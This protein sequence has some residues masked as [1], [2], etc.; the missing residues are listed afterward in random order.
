MNVS[1]MTNEEIFEEMTS[2]SKRMK[3]LE[4][5]RNY[6]ERN[7]L[8]PRWK[9]LHAAYDFGFSVGEKIETKAWGHLQEAKIIQVE[10]TQFHI[11]ND[12]GWEVITSGFTLRKISNGPVVKQIDMFDILGN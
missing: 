2:I 9:E 3:E 12:K 7:E 11:R 1:G 10:G 8:I 6:Q 5:V 4:K